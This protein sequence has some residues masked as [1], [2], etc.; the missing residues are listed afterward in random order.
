MIPELRVDME[1]TYAERTS[2][3]WQIDFENNCI[4]GTVDGLEAVAQ[5]AMMALQTPRYKHLIF[6]GQHGSELETLVG[7]DSDYIFSEGKR[8]ISDA[9]STDTRITGVCD[10]TF[11]NGVISFTLDTIYGSTIMDTGGIAL[12]NL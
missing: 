2:K 5:S 6:S 9:L 11:N 12:E 10:F 3:A 8:M 4:S 1:L 7:M